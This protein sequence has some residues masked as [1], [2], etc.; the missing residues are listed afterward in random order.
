MNR[1]FNAT[2]LD[3]YASRSMIGLTSILVVI[4][5]IIGVVAH[6]PEYMMIFMMVFG[7]SSSGSVFSVHEK[8]RS[9]R[10]Y[11]ILPLKKSDI[12]VGRYLFALII[13][14]AYAVVAAIL[15]FVLSIIMLG[16]VDMLPYLAALAVA[17][18]YFCFATSI[19]YPI[20]FRFSFSKAYVFTMLPMYI[21]AVMLLFATRRMNV[22]A[23]IGPVVKFFTDHTALLPVFGLLAGLIMLTV[24][25]LIAYKVYQRKEL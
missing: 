22:A 3:F 9:D 19:A 12:I 11:G 18:A 4:G 25:A 1:A 6:G 7:V 16:K 2:K 8:S 15:G 24:S 20:Y 17:F 5:I 23:A 21:I 10:L 13:G 14:L